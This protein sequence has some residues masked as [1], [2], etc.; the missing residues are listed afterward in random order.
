M[1]NTQ[2]SISKKVLAIVLAVACMVCFTPSIAFTQDAHAASTGGTV[3][4]ATQAADIATI[5]DTTTANVTGAETANV[6]VKLSKALD[7][8]APIIVGEGVNLTVDANGYDITEST[9]TKD[10][11]QVFTT[12]SLILTNTSTTTATV[13][14][15]ADAINAA[16]AGSL[17]T[18]GT[19]SVGTGVA[20]TGVNGIVVDSA[21]FTGKIQVAGSVTGTTKGIT[22][23]TKASEVSGNGIV[24]G[25]VDPSTKYT[26]CTGLTVTNVTGKTT[27]TA[28]AIGDVMNAA[29]SGTANVGYTYQW[30]A[31]TTQAKADAFDGTA[32]S[33]ATAQRYTV[34]KDVAGK[35]LYCVVKDGTLL[36]TTSAAF[37]GVVENALT[38]ATVSPASQTVLVGGTATDV[39]ATATGGA[40]TTYQWYKSSTKDANK[41]TALTATENALGTGYYSGIKTATLTIG[42]TATA[43]N[44][45]TTYYFCK[46][47]NGASE[48]WSDAVTVDVQAKGLAVKTQPTDLTLAQG[49]AAVATVTTANAD[50]TFVVSGVS[51]GTTFQWYSNSTNAS[52]GGT[53]ISADAS[54][55]KATG[56][57]GISAKI[58]A[59]GNTTGIAF[60]VAST[61]K[62]GTYYFYCTATNGTA[63]AKSNVIALTVA[64]PAVTTS[65]KSKTYAVNDDAVQM[66]AAMNSKN[67]IA[68]T[69]Y[70]STAAYAAAP[71]DAT[72]KAGIDAGTTTKITADNFKTYFTS[73]SNIATGAV[74]PLTTTKGTTY[75]FCMMVPAGSTTNYYTS[76]AKIEV[77][78]TAVTSVTTGNVK[79]TLSGTTAKATKITKTSAKSITIAKTVSA[80]GKTYKVTGI[81]SKV[82]AKSKATTVTVKSTTLTKAGVKNCFKSSKVK[83]VKV[84][85]AK[86]S[87]YKKIF[88]KSNCGKTVTVK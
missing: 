56:I 79:Y 21:A 82:F 26:A 58:V 32:I 31:A 30:Y 3:T 14:G 19:I 33:G 25:G 10:A 64:A 35:Y 60:D 83:T 51:T 36:G 63:V 86:K 24:T 76:V 71:T 47:S 45:G 84:P 88:T 11:F 38:G 27:T 70:A 28:P 74:T 2:T 41:A 44:V 20:I 16:V 1:V 39:T 87:A 80:N 75:F 8:S 13:T 68:Y 5:F 46:V 67:T 77:G 18:T 12:G 85:K 9:A 17:A 69:W 78:A 61:A 66:K 49:D 37:T 6:T 52:T 55:A 81:A 42:G 7:I 4:A 54:V 48:A 72:V 34:T 73:D 15:T 23:A 53:A 29:A 43:A 50:T 62:A 59:G 65:P 40:A 57:T 22:N